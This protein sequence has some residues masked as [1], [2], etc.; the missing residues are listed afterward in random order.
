MKYKE[1]ID[2]MIKRLQ[3]DGIFCNNS[4]VK[5]NDGII[6]QINSSDYELL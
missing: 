3:E 5:N 6:Y 1:Q 2:I 4:I